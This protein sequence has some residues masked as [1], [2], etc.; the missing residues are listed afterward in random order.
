M[1]KPRNSPC[2]SRQPHEKPEKLQNLFLLPVRCLS[3]NKS[4]HAQ[5][6]DCFFQASQHRWYATFTGQPFNPTAQ[7]N[8]CF[9]NRPKPFPSSSWMLS[10]NI[11]QARSRTWKQVSQH[12]TSAMP[13]CTLMLKN[14][15]VTNCQIIISS[16][17]FPLFPKTPL[18]SYKCKRQYT[19]PSPTLGMT[20]L[21]Q[22]VSPCQRCSPGGTW[23]LRRLPLMLEELDLFPCDLDEQLHVLQSQGNFLANTAAATAFT[24]STFVPKSVCC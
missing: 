9:S 5:Q 8:F 22:E 18:V 4:F 12:S 11:L 3:E 10:L 2:S 19:C 24:K 6:W 16:S 1:T 15:Y 14:Q 23:R 13:T 7:Y 17:A 21:L 20:S